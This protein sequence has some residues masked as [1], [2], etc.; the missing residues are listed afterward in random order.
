MFPNRPL[1]ILE[2]WGA[3][4]GGDAEPGV[5]RGASVHGSQNQLIWYNEGR[6]H[7]CGGQQ[8]NELHSRL[9]GPGVN[10]LSM[11]QHRS[12]EFLGS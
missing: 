8:R 12:K 3:T 4:K 11:A 9:S 10:P 1:D 6:A 7:R 5:R 2:E